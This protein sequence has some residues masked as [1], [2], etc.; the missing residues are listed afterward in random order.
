MLYYSVLSFIDKSDI[1]LNVEITQTEISLSATDNITPPTSMSLIKSVTVS[2][3]PVSVHSYDN[4]IY[5]GWWGSG[6]LLRYDLDL[7][8]GEA[9]VKGASRVTSIQAYNNELYVWFAQED[10]IKVYDMTGKPKRSWKHSCMS[11]DINKLRVVSDRVVVSPAQDQALTVYNLQGQLWKR[12]K[13]PGLSNTGSHKAMAV[14]SDDSVIVSDR[15]TNSVFRVNIDSGEVMWTS[16]H[17]QGAEGVV[18][19]KN[20][21]VLVTN[22]NTY[23]KIWILDADTGRLLS[24]YPN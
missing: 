19:Y 8:G 5:L 22:K 12:I 13:C 20:R 16:K 10:L 24:R 9:L 7:S 4:K 1:E 18:C 3:Y 11:K 23:T 15:G 2:Q 14:C 17:V 6:D 21:Y